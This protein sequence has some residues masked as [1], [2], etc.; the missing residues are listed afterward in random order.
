MEGFRKW[1]RHGP[2]VAAVPSEAC[3]TGEAVLSSVA[4]D[5]IWQLFNTR[6]YSRNVDDIDSMSSGSMS[7]ALGDMWRQGC[8]ESPQRQGELELGSDDDDERDN[9][10]ESDDDGL[11]DYL[12]RVSDS[13]SWVSIRDFLTPPDILVLRTAGPQWHHAIFFGSFAALWFF[14]MDKDESE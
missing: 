11:K 8:P 5:R 7:P 13:P 6:G 2:K 14:L 3:S 9:A 12:S 10:V 4:Q 1:V